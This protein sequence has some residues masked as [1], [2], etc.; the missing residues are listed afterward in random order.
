MPTLAIIGAG[1][2]LG[3]A[4]ARR[5]AREGFA[6]S[7][8]SRT[9]ERVRALA[10][11]LAAEGITARGYAA[12]VRDHDSLRSAL[13]DAAADL[14]PI[15]VLQYSPLPAKEFLRPV[16]E[17][18]VRHEVLGGR[19]RREREQEHQRDRPLRPAHGPYPLRRM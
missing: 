12:N 7:L 3:A 19:R 9:A 4:T 6:V 16:L 1:S 18:P 5:F 14:G 11:E 15:D 8:I 13:N 2:Q 17:P 10:D